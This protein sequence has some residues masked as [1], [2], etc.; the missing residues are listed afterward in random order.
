MK[1]PRFQVS[2][3]SQSFNI[4]ASNSRPKLCGD[5]TMTLAENTSPAITKGEKRG[6]IVVDTTKE[7]AKTALD[8]VLKVGV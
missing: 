1:S 8:I 2:S 3:E 4:I 7:L 5:Y 6:Q